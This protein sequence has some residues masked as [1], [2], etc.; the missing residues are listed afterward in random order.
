MAIQVLREDKNNEEISMKE[1][2]VKLKLWYND[3]KSKWLKIVGLGLLAALA[4]YFF[5]NSRVPVFTAT[6][7]FVLENSESATGLGQY[8]GIASMVG[9]D[10]GGGGGGIFQGDNILELY[11]SRTMI[12]K[13][14]LSEVDDNGKKQLLIDRYIDINHL[15]ERW[16]KNAALKDMRFEGNEH[17]Q[18]SRSTR[19]RDSV[20]SSIAGEINRSN[21]V[22]VKPDKNLSIIQ[23]DVKTSDE[24]FSKSFND[25][26][27]KNVND[28]YVQTKTKKSLQNIAI[29]KQ[30]VDSVTRVMNGAIYTVAAV[31]DATPNLNPTRQL[32]RTVPMQRS[33]FSAETNKVILAEL[34]KNLELSKISLLK[35]TPL[36]QIVDDPQFPLDRYKLGNLKAAVICGIAAMAVAAIVRLLKI[37]L[38]G[39]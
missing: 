18:I 36:I 30:K 35:E 2:G 21:L 1:V 23:V 6:T 19:L 28:F 20:L 24:F 39:A 5:A 38:F 17:R 12:E 8:A 11:K 3:L 22:V 27:V 15:R 4:G 26:I 37:L 29:L 34:V 10:L 31:A 7:T 33:Q 32:Q 16:T 14:L 9:L 13:T 25:Q